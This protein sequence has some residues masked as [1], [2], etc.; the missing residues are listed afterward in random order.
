MPTSTR[1]VRV[2]TDGACRGNPGPGGWAWAVDG[3]PWASGHDSDTT[4]QRMEIRAVLEA[5]RHLDGPLVVVSDSTYVVNCWRDRWWQGWIARGWK[6]SQKKPVANRDLW[7]PLVEVFRHRP[8]FAMEWVKGHSGDPMNDLV[9]RLAVAASHGRDGSG[10]GAPPADLLDEPDAGSGRGPGPTSNARTADGRVPAGWRLVI[11][12]LR[13]P[14]LTAD[15][16]L[17]GRVAEILAAQRTLHPDLVVLSGLWPGAEE[18]GARA[19]RS[20]GVPYVVVLPYPDPMAGRPERDQAA[21]ARLLDDAASVVVL[22]RNRPA[23]LE[24]RRAALPRRDGWLRSA[25][26]AA[27]ILTDG[28]DP[29]AELAVRRFGDAVGD[30]LWEFLL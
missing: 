16:A 30:E 29:D 28:A 15:A 21:F 10:V 5:V 7:E 4:N 19:A 1:P 23:D 13:D 14:R 27:V 9:D 12:G 20:A 18:V 11:G 22:E 25:A 26:D 17:I 8:D 6:N 2:Y 24:G 3:G